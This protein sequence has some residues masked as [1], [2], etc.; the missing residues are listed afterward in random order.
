MFLPSYFVVK[1]ACLF[2]KKHFHNFFTNNFTNFNY[3]DK[4]KAIENYKSL[5]VDSLRNK[6]FHDEIN[7]IMNNLQ[8]NNKLFLET[9]RMTCIE[10]I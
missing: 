3:N 9:L 8:T 10:M 1:T 2:N 5:V 7:F 6:E 4:S